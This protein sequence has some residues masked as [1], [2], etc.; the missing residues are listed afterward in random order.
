MLSEI[1][2]SQGGVVK[3]HVHLNPFLE[4]GL[5]YSQILFWKVIGQSWKNP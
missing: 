3:Y 4:R 2:S 5:G 1:S